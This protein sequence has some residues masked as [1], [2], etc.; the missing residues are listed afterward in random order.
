AQPIHE[1]LT[2]SGRW[3]IL[4]ETKLHGDV[5]DDWS[6]IAWTVPFLGQIGGERKALGEDLQR[7]GLALLTFA[8]EEEARLWFGQIRESRIR[9]RLFH[10]DRAQILPP[11]AFQPPVP[12]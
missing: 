8:S 3:V 12:H 9:A 10:P 7:H 5:L 6:L 11:D 4:L 2:R 1:T